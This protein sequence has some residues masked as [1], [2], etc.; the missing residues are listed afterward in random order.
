MRERVIHSGVREI[1]DAATSTQPGPSL[2]GALILAALAFLITWSPVGYGLVRHGVTIVHE[3]GHATV[4]LLCGRQ[5]RG[6]RLH[7]DTSGVTVS[8]GRPRGPG[9]IATVAAGYPAPA[10]LGLA[11]AWLLGQG[12]AVGWLWLMVALC[13]L[14]LVQIRNFYGLWVLLVA[15][16]VIGGATW[17]LP[18]QAAGWLAHLLVWA[19]LLAAPRSV[20]ELQRLR[21][22]GSA[23]RSDADQLARLTGL[24]AVVWIGLFWLVCAGCLLGG[25]LLL[26]P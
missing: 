13:A 25:A 5:L 18:V 23:R 12:Y 19:L 8:R 16:L 11:S 17:L 2:A 26:L 24:P 7:A 6:I 4:A 22:R 20:V 9:M 1:W 14:M 21:R 3:A 15:G 10:L